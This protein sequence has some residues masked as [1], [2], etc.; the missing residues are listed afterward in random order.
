[1]GNTPKHAVKHTKRTRKRT[2][3]HL[4]KQ[5][6]MRHNM[7]CHHSGPGMVA[8]VHGGYLWVRMGA[9]DQGGHGDTR[10]CGLGYNRSF[11]IQVL[12]EN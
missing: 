2:T 3:Y 4:A 11:R 6:K 1:M 10:E 8:H 7:T 9:L 12:N 5:C